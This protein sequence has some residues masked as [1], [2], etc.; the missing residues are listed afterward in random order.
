MVYVRG[1]V[2]LNA[3]GRVG[4]RKTWARREEVVVVKVTFGREEIRMGSEKLRRR[5]WVEDLM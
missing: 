5:F 3:P 2:V 4:V 1:E